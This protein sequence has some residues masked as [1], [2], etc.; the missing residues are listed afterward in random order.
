M[1]NGSM[2]PGTLMKLS[3]PHP[4]NR[5]A[6]TRSDFKSIAY[7]EGNQ[8]VLVLG[9]STEQHYHGM[10]SNVVEILTACGVRGTVFTSWLE[11]LRG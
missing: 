8:P 1:D 5:Y 6:I 9:T 7:V 2:K 10:S 3:G 11:E 4:T